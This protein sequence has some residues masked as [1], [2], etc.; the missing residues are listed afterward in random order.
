MSDN[1]ALAMVALKDVEAPVP[2]RVFAE[3]KKRWPDAPPP[4]EVASKNGALTFKLDDALAAVALMP[5]PIP[6]SALEGPCAAAWYWPKAAEAMK[7]HP[8]HLLVT[9][10]GGRRTPIDRCLL[11]TALTASVTAVSKA[12]GVYWGAGPVLQSPA[13]FLEVASEMKQDYLPLRLWID[14][15]LVRER[16]GVHSVY[17]TG[18]DAFGHMDLELPK[19]RQKPE[20]LF[21]L[22]FNAAHY[23]LD[24]GPVLKDG[25]TFGT[26]AEQK[27]KVRHVPSRWGHAGKILSL[28]F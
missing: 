8:S 27:I 2:E 1:P 11:L 26:S 15:R 13:A 22:A 9:L 24:R 23:L 5:A 19:S 16:P 7:A 21:D 28:N 25:D 4:R 6:W 18:L 3:L 14:F 17:T 10:S 12:A 20:A